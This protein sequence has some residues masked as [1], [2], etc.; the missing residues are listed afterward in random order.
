MHCWHRLLKVSKLRV[1]YSHSSLCPQRHISNL[2][3]RISGSYC[4]DFS[5]DSFNNGRNWRWWSCSTLHDDVFWVYN[6]VSHC[7]FG[8]FHLFVLNNSLLLHPE[9]Q[10]SGKGRC[11]NWLRFGD[12]HA[13]RSDDGQH[14]RGPRQPVPPRRNPAGF[15]YSPTVFLDHSG[16]IQSQINI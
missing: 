14:D 11:D 1:R 13:A 4:V 8:F 6:Q 3:K 2:R 15:S 7:N 16:W 9:R 10:T 12:N 5:N